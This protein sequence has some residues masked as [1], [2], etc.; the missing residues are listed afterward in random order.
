VPHS[1][2]TLTSR[3]NL[4]GRGITTGGI[5]R[6]QRRLANATNVDYYVCSATFNK[7]VSGTRD[8]S[9]SR[10]NSGRM[11][12]Y[13]WL[14][15]ETLVSSSSAFSQVMPLEIIIIGAG[16]AGLTTA[17]SLH[18][19]GHHVRVSLGQARF[20]FCHIGHFPHSD[21]RPTPPRPAPPR[22]ILLPSSVVD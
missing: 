11:Y 4:T 15:S 22:R 20:P 8:F 2:I 5:A 3:F 16:I 1:T 9:A 13:Y 6:H 17:V 7:F 12:I 10:R 14:V 18:R 21:S 19:A